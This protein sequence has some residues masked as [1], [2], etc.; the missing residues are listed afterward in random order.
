MQVGD[1]FSPSDAPVDLPNRYCAHPPEERD[2]DWNKIKWK[3]E[4]I[5]CILDSSKQGM[6]RFSIMWRPIDQNL[7]KPWTSM[8]NAFCLKPGPTCALSY[9]AMIE[10]IHSKLKNQANIGN[11]VSQTHLLLVVMFWDEATSYKSD[12]EII[13][14]Y[15]RANTTNPEFKQINSRAGGISNFR[16]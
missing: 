16:W 3:Y 10:A 13:G 5:W 4:N 1:N 2:E 14:N 7:V 6:R 11:L 12:N 15:R 9:K 8:L